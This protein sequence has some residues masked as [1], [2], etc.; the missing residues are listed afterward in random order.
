MLWRG[1]AGPIST[2]TMKQLPALP[3]AEQYQYFSHLWQTGQR[4]PWRDFQP[5]PGW[6]YPEADRLR[7]AQLFR[8][9]D[10]LVA[11]RRCVDL[12]CHTGFL[13][14]IARHL[15]ASSVRAANCRLEPIELGRFAMQELAIR[16]V[17]FHELDLE[18]VDHVE[19][20]CRGQDTVIMADVLAHTR[21]PVAVLEALTRSGVSHLLFQ[22]ALAPDT[23]LAQLTYSLQSTQGPYQAWQADR[24][25][26]LAA[27]PNLL[28]IET[29]LYSL[30]WRVEQ[31]EVDPV[32]QLDWFATPDLGEHTPRSGR[33]VTLAAT[34]FDRRG[35]AQSR[36][37][38]RDRWQ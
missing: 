26:A 22:S 5:R 17:E 19:S 14:L 13:S 2:H 34:R 9:A 1:S 36:P 30:G 27:R 15:G 8:H 24:T 25:H 28:W 10:R 18:R 6:Q 29:V 21:N 12:G 38:G 20:L 37:L 4:I 3:P 16:H 7:L 11:G 35:L 32:V 23:G 31:H 33:R